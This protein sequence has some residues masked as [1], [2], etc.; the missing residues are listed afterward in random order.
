MTWFHQLVANRSLT[1]LFIFSLIFVVYLPSFFNTFIWDDEQ[2]IVRNVF[3]TSLEYL[4][5]VFTTNTI[6]GA[7]EL[8]NYYRPLTTISFTIDRLIWGLTPF[9][10]HLT[11]TVL[12]AGTAVLIWW[13]LRQLKMKPIPTIL[14]A[15]VFGLHPLQTESV[16]YI[17]S[18][19]DSLYS[20]WM[21]VSLISFQYVLEGKT[22][23]LKMGDSKATFNSLKFSLIS[24]MAFV[25]SIL[26][27]EIALAGFG[28]LCWLWLANAVKHKKYFQPASLATLIGMTT[29]VATYLGLRLTVLN[30]QNS[31][32][33]YEFN[34]VYTE[35]VGVRMLTFA[36]I[37]FVYFRLILFPYPLHMERTEP[38]ITALLNG[39]WLTALGLALALFIAGWWEWKRIKSLWIWLGSSW[40]FCFLI[41]VSG[42]VPI[43]GLIY[44][45]WLYMPLIGFCIALY[46]LFKVVTAIWPKLVKFPLKI[47]LISFA[48]LLMLYSGLTLRQNWLWRS[49]IPFY[50]YTL[51]FGESARLFNNLAMAYDAEREHELAVENYHRALSIHP[52]Y[53]QIH[54]NLARTYIELGRQEDAKASLKTS[55]EVSQGQFEYATLLLLDILRQEEK[56]SEAE[57]LI[58]QLTETYPSS[59]EF[60]LVKG[61]VLWKLDRKEDA[62]KIWHRAYQLSG[63]DPQISSLIDSFKRPSQPN[64][65]Q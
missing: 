39:W 26:A 22:K 10:F 62:E 36:R 60:A 61:E 56:Y 6:A 9:G 27:K 45:H 63:F 21:L 19:G 58:S 20:F 48:L 3:T 54:Y 28:V 31:L 30:F 4:P 23:L 53:P 43:N 50:S 13:F 40:F 7:G 37:L 41:P 51:Q 11:N 46:G 29:T 42:I 64:S 52:A 16:T 14:I 47:G 18:R 2:F 5:Q 8:S 55:I 38:V 32:N 59:V 34:N 24:I 17:N 12:H 15:L 44:E 33:F 1:A 57:P 49:P 35:N 65:H 25:L